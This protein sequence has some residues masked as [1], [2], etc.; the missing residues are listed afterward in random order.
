MSL[1]GVLL[2]TFSPRRSA[3]VAG[4]VHHTLW[5]VGRLAG[6]PLPSQCLQQSQAN[7]HTGCAMEGDTAQMYKCNFQYPPV[8]KHHIPCC[9]VST[10]CSHLMKHTT[11]QSCLLSK[12]TCLNDEASLLWRL[13][14]MPAAS[15]GN[16]TSTRRQS[17]LCGQSAAGLLPMGPAAHESHEP[18]SPRGR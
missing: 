2:E 18:C 13:V 9:Y 10:Q 1:M 6:A 7:K 4:Q 11:Q 16:L 5:C 15:E 17:S 3:E 12:S 8:I 14:A